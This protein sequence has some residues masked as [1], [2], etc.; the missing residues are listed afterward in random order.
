MDGRKQLHI[1]LCKFHATAR[2][3]LKMWFLLGPTSWSPSEEDQGH[4]E[5][6]TF[7]TE[8]QGKRLLGRCSINRLQSC[9]LTPVLAFTWPC[10]FFPTCAHKS[11]NAL[12]IHG[13]SPAEAKMYCSLRSIIFLYIHPSLLFQVLWDS[14]VHDLILFL[15]FQ[16]IPE[17]ALWEAAQCSGA[18]SRALLGRYLLRTSSSGFWIQSRML[19]LHCSETLLGHQQQWDCHLSL[20]TVSL[21]HKQLLHKSTL[22]SEFLLF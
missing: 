17:A 7:Q 10:S 8:S 4:T 11:H 19:C 13:I 14:M 9:W 21:F 18:D 16:A 12:I 6:Q 2:F 22:N 5:I 15:E 20:L 1:Q 3:S